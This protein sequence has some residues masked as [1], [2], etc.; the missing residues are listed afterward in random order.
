MEVRKGGRVQKD[1]DL[2]IQRSKG[3]REG[4]RVCYLCRECGGRVEDVDCL[5]P[6]LF[7]HDGPEEGY[8]LAGSAGSWT[9][10]RHPGGICR[11]LTR[12]LANVVPETVVP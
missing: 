4:R 6:E 9:A 8:P 11:H 10:L 7:V 3:V 1:N 2:G 12:C 5:S